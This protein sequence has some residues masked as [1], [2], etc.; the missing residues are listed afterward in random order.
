MPTTKKQRS[1]AR[2]VPRVKVWIEIDGSY[3]FGRGISDILK[4]VDEVGSIKG[5]AQT[6]G[7][8]YRHVW[9]RVK[10]AEQAL[11]A[12]LVATQ[13]GGKDLQRSQLTAL[14]RELVSE[15]DRLRVRMGRLLADEFPQRL[16]TL[17][18][19]SE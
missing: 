6:L 10:E 14:G 7:K 17:L 13:V 18:R 2:L 8:S 4:A 16:Q 19:G 3:V 9:S 12:S 1:G 5:A 11:G 15:F